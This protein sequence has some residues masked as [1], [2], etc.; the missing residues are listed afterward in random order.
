MRMKQM[1]PSDDD[2]VCLE[3]ERNSREKERFDLDSYAA[4]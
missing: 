3:E 2:D 4:E 1:L